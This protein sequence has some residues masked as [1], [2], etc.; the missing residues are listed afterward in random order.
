[1]VCQAL[2]ER[3]I[4]NNCQSFCIK[5]ELA[6]KP[7]SQV[8]FS[9]SFSQETNCDDAGRFGVDMNWLSVFPILRGMVPSLRQRLVDAARQK[10]LPPNSVIFQPGQAP[11]ALL[12]VLAGQ[13]RVQQVSEQGREIVL[14]RIAAGES[15]ILTTACLFADENYQAT[16]IA[17]TEVTALAIP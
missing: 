14:Y 5:S 13:V 3:L 10:F 16:A 6:S 15:C 1:M 8:N 7:R 9:A 2:A 12:L 11:D 17:E 4:D